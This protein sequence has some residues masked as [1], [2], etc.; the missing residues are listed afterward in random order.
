MV[1]NYYPTELHKK[2][3]EDFIKFFKKENRVMS[4]LLTCSCARGKAHKS[5]CIDFAFVVKNIKKDEDYLQKKFEQ[6]KNNSKTYKKFKKLDKF[7][8]IDL[9]IID[10]NFKPGDRGICSQSSEFELEIGNYIAYSVII[11]EKDNYFSKIR[12][13]YLPYYSEKLRK[14]RLN[15]TIKFCMNH[16]DHIDQFVKRGL[17][18]QA[19]DRLYSSIQGFMQALFIKNKIYPIAYDK[20]IKDQ[21]YDLLKRPD[22]Y[23]KIVEIISIKNFESNEINLKAKKL[24]G[25]I[26]KE[27]K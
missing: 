21:Y 25:L 22:L 20:W 19:Y 2:A 15:R 12:K 11:F 27:L 13:R 14:Y 23:K 10:G 26:D 1:I 17:H 6:F 4:I 3:A 8:H 18:F 7:T 16:L 9:E 24:M 5:S